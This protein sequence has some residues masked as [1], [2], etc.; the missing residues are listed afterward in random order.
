[1]HNVKEANGLKEQIAQELS[2]AATA[3]KDASAYAGGRRLNPVAGTQQD[4]SDIDYFYSHEA[5]FGIGDNMS[6]VSVTAG[7]VTTL[8]KFADR[9]SATDVNRL[10]TNIVQQQSFFRYMLQIQYFLNSVTTVFRTG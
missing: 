8:Q 2:R 3:Y 6:E 5:E 1:V 10:S 9:V 4:A 7:V